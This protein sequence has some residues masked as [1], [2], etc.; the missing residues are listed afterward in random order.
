MRTLIVLFLSVLSVSI[1]AKEGHNDKNIFELKSD[2][3]VEKNAEKK[4]Y[5]QSNMAT[6]YASEKITSQNLDEAREL[7]SSL[8]IASKDYKSNWNYSNAIHLAH[9]VLGRVKFFQNDIEGA[10]GELILASKVSGSPQ[11]KSFGPNMFLAKELLEKGER[12]VVIKYIDNCLSF[13]RS[14][15][16][17]SKIKNWKK[18]VNE[19]K[20]PDFAGNLFY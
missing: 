5:I 7:A 6:L 12:A 17:K 15:N 20:I 11:L 13:W 1:V 10:K 16:A 4:F 9:L 19:G 3:S 8:L 14:K 2:F 18:I